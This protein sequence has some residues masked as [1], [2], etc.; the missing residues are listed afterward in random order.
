M[1]KR[2]NIPKLIAI[3]CFVISIPEL[4]NDLFFNPENINIFTI[5]QLLNPLNLD[6]VL[7]GSLFKENN[8][9]YIN[10]VFEGLLLLGGILYVVTKRADTRLIRVVASVVFLSNILSFVHS[11]MFFLLIKSIRLVTAKEIIWELFFYIFH[12]LW[13]YL[14]YKA[15]QYFKTSR[16]LQTDIYGEGETQIASFTEA[17]LWQRFLHPIIDTVIA[18]MLFSPLIQLFIMRNGMNNPFYGLS[19]RSIPQNLLLFIIIASRIVYYL[20]FEGILGY[21]PAKL[22]TETRV[23]DYEGN[24]PYFPNIA[25]RT[26]LR[27]IPFESMSFFVHKGLHDRLS[28]TIVVKEKQTGTDGINYLW[29]IPGLLVLVFGTMFIKSQYGDYKKHRQVSSVNE[30]QEAEIEQN[31]QHAD[32]NYFF[33]LRYA[34]AQT[35]ANF[36]AHKFLKV[37]QVDPGSIT[38]SVVKVFMKDGFGEITEAEVTNAYNASKDTLPKITLSKKALFAALNANRISSSDPTSTIVPI[39]VRGSAYTIKSIENYYM[40]NIKL[41]DGSGYGTHYFEILLVNKGW[42]ADITNIQV[43]EGDIKPTTP[44]PLHVSKGWSRI[45]GTAGSD[46][47]DFKMDI[48]VTDSLNRNQVY[49]I[50]GNTGKD[51]DRYIKK[52][53]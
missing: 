52:I 44:L 45:S 48:T 21:T 27:L 28:K 29:L 26:F 13:I 36:K 22:F 11:L 39:K 5:K 15:L 18:I 2:H 9:N 1:E 40:P 4:Y 38:F 53:K 41:F 7:S 14:S 25:G 47:V 6:W 16:E 12:A 50:E 42:K 46:A 49:E 17:S 51:G 24:K 19:Y 23:T 10:A 34:D 32:T 43:L 8:L 33:E 31:L 37:Q 3:L 30:R 20:L 35:D